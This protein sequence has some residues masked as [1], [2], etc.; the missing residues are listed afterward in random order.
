MFAVAPEVSTNPFQHIAAANIFRL[1]TPAA[2]SIAP[3]VK[4]PLPPIALTGIVDGYGELFAL[5]EVS[6]ANAPK[7]SLK[8]GPGESEGGVE[9]LRV[10]IKAGTVEVRISDTITNLVLNRIA[11]PM[12]AKP[13]AQPVTAISQNA[14]PS[15]AQPKLGRD[16]TALVIEAERERLRQA[17]DPTATLMPITHLRP[18]GAP[19]TE[20][21]L[22]RSTTPQRKFSWTIAK[23]VFAALPVPVVGARIKSVSARFND[24][25]SQPSP[26]PTFAMLRRGQREER[27]KSALL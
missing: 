2:E 23:A 7:M 12:P 15:L 14:V 16:E 13:S 19:G 27:A 10:D 20:A 9:V 11:P 26:P 21:F 18:A 5:L 25:L 8:L 1:R 4:P 3:Q 17:G 6:A 22:R 24:L